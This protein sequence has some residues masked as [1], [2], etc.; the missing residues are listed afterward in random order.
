MGDVTYTMMT[1]SDGNSFRDTGPLWGE[2]T[3]HRWILLT[4]AIDVELWCFLWPRLNKRQSKQSRRRW[5]E[6]QSRPLWRHCDAH[7]DYALSHPPLVFHRIWLSDWLADWLTDWFPASLITMTSKWAPSI[8]SNH[9][10]PH[11]LLS[12]LFGR[13]SKKTSNLRVTGLCAGNSPGTGDRIPHACSAPSQYNADVVLFEPFQTN[14][15][16]TYK[17]ITISAGNDFENIVCKTAI[18]LS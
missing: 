7:C 10:P 2:S 1:S 12:R 11:C 8:V 16:E 13:I 17:H 4:M 5:F 15:S 9:Q 18:I 3:G 14:V 6:T